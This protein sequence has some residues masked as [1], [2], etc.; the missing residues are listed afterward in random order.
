[1]NKNL[2]PLVLAFVVGCAA[3][4]S[5]D[6]ERTS[7]RLTKPDLIYVNG[8][9]VQPDQLQATLGTG[10]TVLIEL[11]P[12][13]RLSALQALQDALKAASPKRLE[14]RGSGRWILDAVIEQ[15]SNREGTK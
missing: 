8:Q 10:K 14:V 3:A 15:R 2:F 9:L 7:V 1:V 4:G 5:P 11:D 6:Q 13:A 12:E